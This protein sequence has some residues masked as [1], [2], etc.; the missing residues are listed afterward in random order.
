[1]EE[2]KNDGVPSLD[3][4]YRK[5]SP[6]TVPKQ[7]RF[8]KAE[9]IGLSALIASP[10]RKKIHVEDVNREAEGLYLR[11][12][13]MLRNFSD[14]EGVPR[15][16]EGRVVDVDSETG[17]KRYEIEME[18][19]EGKTLRELR[20]TP[21]NAVMILHRVGEIA[22]K[23]FGKG[24]IYNDFKPENIMISEEQGKTKVWLI[25]FNTTQEHVN[26]KI[27]SHSGTRTYAPPEKFKP[28]GIVD[29]RSDIYSLT[30]VIAERMGATLADTF[31][32]SGNK[33]PEIA[34]RYEVDSLAQIIMPDKLRV[35]L[36]W[37]L[38]PDPGYRCQDW[39]EFLVYLGLVNDVNVSADEFYDKISSRPS[40]P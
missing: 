32:T 8:Q 23:I 34:R 15:L 4:A 27:E 5:L 28:D 36:V 40:V 14:I 39:S 26:G 13:A 7:G 38:S 18:K 10:E 30:A 19:V 29:A 25:D 2:T 3:S 24:Y 35:F 31:F 9:P 11:E 1:M 21:E 22:G 12:M 20:L 17:L 37:N 6:L 16:E 33:S